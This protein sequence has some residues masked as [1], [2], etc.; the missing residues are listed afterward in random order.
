MFTNI[1]LE[2]TMNRKEINVIFETDKEGRFLHL[3]IPPDGEQPQID[4]SGKSRL[5]LTIDEVVRI[6]K[7]SSKLYEEIK[8]TD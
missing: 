7:Y 3:V 8:E 1:I 4:L 6:K 2:E 5:E